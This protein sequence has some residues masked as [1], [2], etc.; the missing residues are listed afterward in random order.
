MIR[1]GCIGCGGIARA[2]AR[3]ISEAVPGVKLVAAADISAEARE[4]FGEDFGVPEMFGSYEEMLRKADMD[5]VCV[6]LPTALHRQATLAAAR[7]GV[8]VMCEKPMAL[9]VRDCD[10]MI[11]ACEKAGLKLM[12]AH[13]RRYDNFWGKL[14]EIVDSGVIGRP[15]LWR[16]V[17]CGGPKQPWFLDAEIGGGP[18]MDGCVHNYE[19]AN[20]MFGKPEEAMGS[21]MSLHPSTAPDTGAMVVRYAS[22]DEIM[23]A[24]CWALRKS[25]S[26]GSTMD[27]LGPEGAILFP[28]YFPESEYPKGFDQ[29]K[30]GAF[31]VK[32]D[33]RK[34][35]VRYRKNSMMA[36]EWKDF[37]DA[38]RQDRSPLATP[39]EARLAV[40]VAQAVLK[41][42]TTHRPVRIRT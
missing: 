23:L 13:C 17:A 10:V 41:A 40:A 5:A 4:S 29:D 8:H 16:A 35:L 25:H 12:I 11:N 14:K 7:A 32:T 9:T 27:L 6:A 33:G 30:Q 21:L 2:H 15:L 28:G 36:G 31:L 18:Y 3:T 22:G 26:G 37:R 20:W 19:F 24:W 42:G 38:I 39:R 34:K 1:V